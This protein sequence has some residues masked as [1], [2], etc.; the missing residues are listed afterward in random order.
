MAAAM[1]PIETESGPGPLQAAAFLSEPEYPNTVPNHHDR[2]PH[3]D[4]N[5]PLNSKP[6]VQVDATAAGHP[7]RVHRR[8]IDVG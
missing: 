3:S 7:H 2:L 8:D 1:I 5:F 6:L 4:E